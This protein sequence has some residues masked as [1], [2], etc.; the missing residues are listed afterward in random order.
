VTV[1]TGLAGPAP[2][3]PRARYRAAATRAVGTAVGAAVGAAVG[4]WVT[5]ELP[6]TEALP[7]ARAAEEPAGF[8]EYV[9][10]RR[11]AL[12]RVA[13]ALTGDWALAEDLL[14]TALAK[15]WPKWT[16]IRRTDDPDVYVRRVLVTTYSTWWRRKWRGEIPT[17]DLPEPRAAG[18]WTGAAD[19][20]DEVA[21]A[22]TLRVALSGLPRRQRAVVVLRYVEDLPEADVAEILGCS[23]GTVK[24]QASKGLAKLR[25]SPL[26]AGLA[27]DAPGEEA[28]A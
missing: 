19:P 18:G 10:A 23:V 22:E 25:G 14:Q 6:G 15:V 28:S 2:A 13:W 27:A 24:S 11:N 9:A 16:S 20:A 3:L 4:V 1:L 5:D 8:R 17:G 12:L 21:L 26:L 7:A